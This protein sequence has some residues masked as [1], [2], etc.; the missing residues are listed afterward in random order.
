MLIIFLPFG[1]KDS[2]RAHIQGYRGKGHQQSRETE[3]QKEN[4]TEDPHI[5]DSK[6]VPKP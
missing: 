6:A 1:V 3:F 5:P 2:W 4:H